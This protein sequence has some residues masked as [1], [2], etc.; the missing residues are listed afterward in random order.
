MLSDDKYPIGFAYAE[1]VNDGNEKV[2]SVLKSLLLKVK[3][4]DYV[5]ENLR[6]NTFINA[7]KNVIS[8]HYSTNNFYNEPASIRNLASL[9]TIIPTPA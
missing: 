2:S 7:A 6:S 1:V 8:V 3:G 5:P 4:F 9:G